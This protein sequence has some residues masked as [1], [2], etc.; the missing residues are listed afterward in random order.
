L[1]VLAAVVSGGNVGRKDKVRP[2]NEQNP[3]VVAVVENDV[4]F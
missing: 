1:A 3:L 2:M 4:D